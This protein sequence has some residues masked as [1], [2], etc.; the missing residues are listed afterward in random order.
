MWN[1]IQRIYVWSQRVRPDYEFSYDFRSKSVATLTADWWLRP[2]WSSWVSFNS[3]GMYASQSSNGYRQC[4]YPVS[5]I[6]ANKITLTAHII[7][8]SSDRDF[9]LWIEQTTSGDKPLLM[10]ACSYTA[11]NFRIWNSS[12]T[13]T[14]FG[15]R[16]AM[17]TSGTFTVTFTAD[18]VAKTVSVSD[19]LHSGTYSLTDQQ[20]SDIVNNWQAIRCGVQKSNNY[21]VD[22]NLEIKY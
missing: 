13:A 11:T 1:K 10:W 18:L 16:G 21:F 9:A 7:N 2:K 20:V 19:G 8:S 4:L 12:S 17:S 14:V 6:G 22:V 15:S 3:S 5:F